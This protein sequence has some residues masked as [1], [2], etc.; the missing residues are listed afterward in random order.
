MKKN[1]F[2]AQS[3]G[4]TSV[5]NATA[6]A[7]I[8]EAKKHKDKI[9][10]VYAGKNGILGALREEL[11]DTS[12]ES[13]TAI[14]SLK[15]RAGGVFGSC[16]LK[17]KDFNE[18]KKEYERLVDVFKAHNIGYFFYNGGNDS[19]DTAYKV[20]QI[21]NSLSYP[22]KCIAIPKTV[23][24]D[25]AVTDC[26]PG[27]GSAA[28]YIATS[29]LE[30]SLDVESMSET[31]TKVFI[32]EV[33]GRHAGWMAASSALARTSKN[34]APHIILFPEVRFNQQRFLKKIKA[35]VKK[36]GYC[37][38]V[39]SEGVKNSKGKFLAE[40]DTKDAFGHTQ[41]GGV[42]PYLASLVTKKLQLK[43][44]WAV[45]DYLQRSARH[46][47]SKTDLLHAEAVGIHAVKYAIQGLNGVMPV[48]IRGKG[49]KYSW[50]IKPAPLSKIANV[51]RKLPKA[52][53]TKD[54]FNVNTKAIKYLQPLILGEAYPKFYNGV[55]KIE[56]LKLIEV[57]KKL[58]KWK[59]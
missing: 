14:E 49:S 42:A 31:S 40:S 2:Y 16:R 23:D 12:K 37:V 35:V 59:F 52:F 19:A 45:S 27:F 26:C 10:K 32:L 3:G 48:I 51:E 8:L 20:S 58:P 7:L 30:A 11:I 15:S 43:N 13:I 24:N 39:A 36:N 25:L 17:L 47:S 53:I 34:N 57:R 50:K 18:N 41:L 21:S 55:P 54:G 38:I 46:I 56:Q 33:M 29:T 44:H 5:I 1:A 6:A 28:K 4:V 9:G 22:I